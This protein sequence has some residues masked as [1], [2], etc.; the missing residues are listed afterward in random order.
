MREILIA[1]V[2]KKSKEYV[3]TH[4]EIKL[5]PAQKKRLNKMETLIKKGLPLAYVL[6]YKWFY[7]HKICV[8]KNVLIP[9]P[10]TETLVD[11]AISW[12]K[13]NKPKTIIDIGTGSGAIIVSLKRNIKTKAQFFGSDISKKTLLVAKQNAKGLN[14]SFKQGNLSSPFTK[15]LKKNFENVL[16]TAN[17]PYLEPKQLLEKSI[18]KEPRLALV[19]GKKGL[20]KIE[21]LLKQLSK[22]N[23]KNSL[24]LLEIN[25]N[26]AKKLSSVIHKLMPKAKTTIHKDLA[27]WDRIVEIKI[28]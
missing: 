15:L 24:I 27:L 10:E 7:G 13:Q 19:G 17:L 9:R 11:L 3:L 12:A 14:I 1:E 21:R 16:I 26:Q 18:L 5:S 6:S 22:L 23:L 25:Y 20:E 8:N 28:K 4:P 2:L